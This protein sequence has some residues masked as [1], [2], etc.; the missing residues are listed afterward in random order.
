ML[1]LEDPGLMNKQAL[2]QLLDRMK[3]PA[4]DA[5]SDE[6][7]DALVLAFCAACP[8]PV[9]ARWLLLDCLASLTDEELVDRALAAK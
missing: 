3:P 4:S 2:L 7:F 6:E 9:R 1:L 5:L 8:D